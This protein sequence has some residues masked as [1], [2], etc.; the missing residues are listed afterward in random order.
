[1][2][3]KKVRSFAEVA[4]MD[5]ILTQENGTISIRQMATRCCIAH[6]AL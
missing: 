6:I 3:Q 2:A 5:G 4:D 1:M